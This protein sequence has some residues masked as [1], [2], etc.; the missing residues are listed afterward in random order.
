MLRLEL[1]QN[2]TGR[3]A[4][5]LRLGLKPVDLLLMHAHPLVR[6]LELGDAL[7]DERGELVGSCLNVP[8]IV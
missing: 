4:D 8:S 2:R 7:V 1:V 6:T 3:R 5:C